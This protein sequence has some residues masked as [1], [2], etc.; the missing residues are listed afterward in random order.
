MNEEERQKFE[1][2][3]EGA[4]PENEV[5]TTGKKKKYFLESDGQQIKEIVYREQMLNKKENENNRTLIKGNHE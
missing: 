3:K 1:E 4:N 5:R 2:L